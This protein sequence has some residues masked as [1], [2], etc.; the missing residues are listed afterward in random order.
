MLMVNLANYIEQY[1]ILMENIEKYTYI[2]YINYKML[3]SIGYEIK[4]T[5]LL[6]YTIHYLSKL[7][8]KLCIRYL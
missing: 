6:I 5:S 3:N 7:K 8:I 2:L 4:F 1:N